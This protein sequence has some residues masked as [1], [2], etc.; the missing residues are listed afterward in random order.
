MKKIHVST[1]LTGNTPDEIAH[2]KENA[3]V[4]VASCISE[5]LELVE[6]LCEAD[7]AYFCKGWQGDAD[8]VVKQKEAADSGIYV[9]EEKDDGTHHHIFP[10]MNVSVV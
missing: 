6:H 5:P 3:V 8:C 7:V 10:R 4:F 9:I 1:P 2:A